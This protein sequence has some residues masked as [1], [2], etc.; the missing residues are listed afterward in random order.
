MPCD[1]R[2]TL[3]IGKKNGEEEGVGGEKQTKMGTQ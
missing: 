3:R 1:H 2:E